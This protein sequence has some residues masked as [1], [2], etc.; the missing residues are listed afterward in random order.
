MGTMDIERIE[1]TVMA[2]N[3]YLVHAPAGIVVVDGQ[4]TRSDAIAVRDAVRATGKPLAGVLITHPHPDHY[5]GAGLIAES[6]E[7]IVSTA[8]VA[9][10]IERDDVLKDSVVGQ[11]MGAQW[12]N[13]RRLPDRIVDGSITLGGQDFTVY[14]VGQGESHADS[15]W[16]V[17]DAAFTGDLVC[18]D[19]DAYLADGHHA[20]W[21][22]A[23]DTLDTRIGT[24]TCYAG[25][26]GP[27]PAGAIEAQRTYIQTFVDSVRGGAS[28]E[29]VVARMTGLVTDRR[30]QFLMQLSIAP[31]RAEFAA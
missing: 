7:P 27:L 10:I 21:L 3:S 8:S 26:G 16:T 20:A 29:Q 2:V 6:G 14:D 11:M 31:I 22:D 23:L 19:V 25:H 5:A 12:P 28:D 30:L 18:A 15:I 1:G 4:L 17:G 9:A 13:E 24:R